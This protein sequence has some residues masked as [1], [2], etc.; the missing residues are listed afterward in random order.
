MDPGKA[1]KIIGHIKTELVFMF[2][3]LCLPPSSKVDD[4]MSLQNVLT[5][6]LADQHR[7]L[8]TLSLYKLQIFVLVH[9]VD[10]LLDRTYY[11]L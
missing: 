3:R 7:R 9:F 4:V 5:S 6:G 11:V 1:S 2:S 8:T 10:N